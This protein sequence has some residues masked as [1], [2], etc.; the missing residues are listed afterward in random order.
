MK[1]HWN[2]IGVKKA[3]AVGQTLKKNISGLQTQIVKN[4]FVE[5]VRLKACVPRA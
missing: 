3:S 4:I 1:N 2:S 5:E